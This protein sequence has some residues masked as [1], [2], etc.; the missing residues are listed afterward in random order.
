MLAFAWARGRGG[1]VR[2]YPSDLPFLR[3]VLHMAL[4]STTFANLRPDLQLNITQV[5]MSASKESKPNNEKELRLKHLYGRIPRKGG[6]LAHQLE[7]PNMY[8][9][10]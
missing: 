8:R 2:L 5:T 9:V 4:S 6:L 7:V 10:L 3:G 1:E